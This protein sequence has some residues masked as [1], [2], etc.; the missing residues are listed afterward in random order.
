MKNPQT[1]RE[2]S[3]MDRR[4]RKVIL[5]MQCD[6]RCNVGLDELARAVNL[7]LSRLRHLFTCEIGRA[8]AQYLKLLKMQ[9]AREL[10]EGERFLSVKQVMDEVGAID[11][12]HFLRD[13]KLAHGMTFTHC[14]LRDSAATDPLSA[15]LMST[16]TSATG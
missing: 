4:V 16:A 13:F 10:A 11:R 1:V 7:S 14:R 6:L 15:S 3:S 8:P 12:S 9:R 5:I 2:E